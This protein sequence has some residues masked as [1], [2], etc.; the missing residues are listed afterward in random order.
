MVKAMQE[1]QQIIDSLKL[2]VSGFRSENKN[3]QTEIQSQKTQYSDLRSE[4]EKIK[5]QLGI[6]SKK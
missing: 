4:I 6:E 5:V 3:L 2:Q 1:Q